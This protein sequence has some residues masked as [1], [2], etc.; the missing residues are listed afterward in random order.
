MESTHTTKNFFDALQSKQAFWLGFI[1][2]VLALGTLGFVL[3]GS[4]LLGGDCSVAGIAV[5]E[6]SGSGSG[7]AAAAAVAAV[8][9]PTA[10]GVP[11]VTDADHIRGNKDAAITI[12][13]Y[14]DFQCPY[15]SRFHPTMLQVMEEYTDSVRWVFR[16]FPLSFH[17]EAV[18]SANAA[19]C[20]GAQDKFWEYA[21]ELFANQTS[22][23]SEFY[24]QLAADLGLNVSKWQTCFDEGT[25]ND[26]IEAQAQ[27]GGAAGVSGT[28]GS[29]VIDQ[30]GN[31]IPIKGALPF[32]SVAAAIDSV[33]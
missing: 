5:A 11:A 33:L 2:A 7:A 20:A 24:A 13:E 10:T 1:T 28:P 29:F 19:E 27:A 8:P 9:T 23:S 26:V 4:C 14:S 31:A 17:P 6:D 25:Y 3:L 21:D 16:H 15:C 30:D 12:I 22:L 18:P 32:S